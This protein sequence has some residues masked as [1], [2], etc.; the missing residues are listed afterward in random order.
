MSGIEIE[1]TSNI[2]QLV[3]Q[4]GQLAAKEI[5]FATA[6]TLTKVAA[7]AREDIKKGLRKDFDLR[8]KF[9]ERGIISADASD[10]IGCEGQ[11]LAEC[12]VVHRNR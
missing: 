8:N 2:K 6:R 11:G 10:E 9:S 3:A 5:P 12:C 7:L 4:L 1:V